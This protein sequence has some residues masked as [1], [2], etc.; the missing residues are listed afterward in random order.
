MTDAW[1]PLRLTRAGADSGFSH[2]LTIGTVT[3]HI[4]HWTRTEDGATAE[5]QSDA[6]MDEIERQLAEAVRG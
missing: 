2:V 3:L 6:E 1:H 5:A 4:R